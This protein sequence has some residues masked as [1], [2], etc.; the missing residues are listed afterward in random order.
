MNDINKP[1]DD[2]LGGL[3]LF[4]FIPVTEVQSIAEPIDSRV[5]EPVTTTT[6]GRW[7]EC[8]ASEGTMKFIEDLQQ[9]D[10]G[11]FHKAKLS[12]FIPKDRTD[13]ADQFEK[14]RNKDF[15]IDYI[16]NNGHRKLIGTLDYPLRFTYSLDTGATVPNKNG[17]TIEFYGDILKKSPTY[18][19]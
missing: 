19:I 11:D 10:Q 8:Y 16:D 18:F 4:N 3:F 17:H 2:N 9:S 15:I 1:C 5:L 13:I 14:M 6:I 7:Y 12:A